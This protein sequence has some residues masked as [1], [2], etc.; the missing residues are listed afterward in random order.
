[1]TF[2][3]T[4]DRL[5]WSFISVARTR[6]DGIKYYLKEDLYESKFEKI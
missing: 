3:V 5:T 2:N 6:K 1:M 4:Y